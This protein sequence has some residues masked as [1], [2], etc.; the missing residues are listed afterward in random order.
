MSPKLLKANPPST[1]SSA[2]Q[3]CALRARTD[4]SRWYRT[5]AIVGCLDVYPDVSY[6]VRVTASIWDA[7]SGVLCQTLQT[8]LV[9]M[10]TASMSSVESGLSGS[11]VRRLVVACESRALLQVGGPFTPPYIA[12]ED[13]GAV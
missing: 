6:P 11:V 2:F 5:T 1:R 4:P 7:G 12:V 3:T 9:G 8:S 13:L 10:V